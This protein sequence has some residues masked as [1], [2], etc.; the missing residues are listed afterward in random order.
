MKAKVSVRRTH[1]VLISMCF[2]SSTLTTKFV[3]VDA[4]W[5]RMVATVNITNKNE[6]HGRVE[7]T[8]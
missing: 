4:M 8:P 3:T 5:R 1:V 7:T 6:R 2:R